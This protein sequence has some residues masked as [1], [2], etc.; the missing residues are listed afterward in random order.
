M[1]DNSS[2]KY[3]LDQSLA[4]LESQLDPAQ[5]YRVNRKYLLH[6]NSI[7]KIKSYPKSKIQLEIVPAVHEEIIISQENVSAF[8]SWM[9]Q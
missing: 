8:K 7:K 9:E 4:D 3:I 2:N 5:F 6:I 1:V